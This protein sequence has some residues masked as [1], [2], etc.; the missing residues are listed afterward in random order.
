MKNL[1]QQTSRLPASIVLICLLVL[2]LSGCGPQKAS[3]EAIV[4]AEN[5]P[6]DEM[7]AKLNDYQKLVKE[8]SRLARKHAAGDVSVTMLY[9]DLRGKTETTTAK[10]QTQMGQM[11]PVQVRRYSKIA[12]SVAPYLKE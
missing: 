8:Y 7:D 11:K 5:G 1:F 3:E 4:T 9:I 10:L 12:A 6:L 2:G